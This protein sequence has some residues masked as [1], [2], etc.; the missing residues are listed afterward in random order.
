MRCS[1]A[2][3]WRRYITGDKRLIVKN[4]STGEELEE[5]YDRL[6]IA[7]GAR[8]VLPAVEGADLKGTFV[9]RFLSD[10]DELLSF[11]EERP[12]KKAVVVGAGYIGL[13]IV[14]NL[15]ELGMDVSLVEVE[16]RVAPAYDPEISEKIEDHLEEK[17]VSVFTGAAVEALA[18]D[19]ERRVRAVRFDSRE[20]Q[21]EVVILGV[22]TRPEV[23]L[24]KEAGARLGDSGAIRVDKRLKTNLPDVWAAGD[25]VE[26]T[27][28]VT[29]EPA[30]V[31]LGDTAN[32][33]GRVAGTNA[34]LGEAN[35]ASEADEDALEFPGVLG[36]GV[37]KVFD[38]GVAKTGLSEE[39]AVEAGFG[40]V[41][42]SIKSVDK[43]GYFPGG[44][45]VFIKLLAD[46]AT[47][48][49]IGAQAVG[50]NVDKYIDLCAT[51]IWGRLSHPDLTNLDLAYAPPFGPVLS[52]VISAAG[53]LANEFEKETEGARTA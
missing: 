48:R 15:V 40:V 20:I 49:L 25:C 5:H 10:S 46:G 22:G 42:A 29:G 39:E 37:F 18:G 14:E 43:A 31:P 4:L 26:T 50:G 34:V 21:A 12:P 17:G 45:P 32:Q 51:A 3:G 13:E 44:S 6:V 53:A 36:T 11:V 7:T 52:P 24:A 19:G 30:W 47:G 41:S 9:L 38:L 28:L 35:G 16:E 8:A 27:N 2:T 23:S 33:M 1:P